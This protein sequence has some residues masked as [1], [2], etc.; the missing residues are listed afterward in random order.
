MND[1]IEKFNE[2]NRK[3]TQSISPGNQ[4]RAEFSNITTNEEDNKRSIAE[5]II[6]DLGNQRIDIDATKQAIQQIAV[7][8]NQI[9]QALNQLA[10]GSTPQTPEQG[11]INMES[12]AVSA[13]YAYVPHSKCKT[14]M[15][16][17][18]AVLNA[19][20]RDQEY[21]NIIRN[22]GNEDKISERVSE[23]FTRRLLG[24]R[25]GS[26]GS[27]QVDTSRGG[28]VFQVSYGKTVN[29]ARG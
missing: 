29:L 11:K 18:I 25:S 26:F 21:L 19:L 16:L 2:E 22:M 17:T 20:L 10:Q 12:L 13:R 15:S 23:L 7:Q 9:T 3:I 24:R 5:G 14:L 8:I 4:S 6:Q 27:V 28:N 1:D